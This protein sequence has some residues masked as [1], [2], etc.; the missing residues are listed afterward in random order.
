[1]APAHHV[2]RG[3]ALETVQVTLGHESLATTIIEVSLSKQ[4]PKM[5]V[6]EHTL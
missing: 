1:M 6:Q 4:A 3:I 2:Q 5:N